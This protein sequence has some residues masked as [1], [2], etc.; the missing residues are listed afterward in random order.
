MAVV[1]LCG[2]PTLQTQFRFKTVGQGTQSTDVLV[3]EEMVINYTY[4][5]LGRQMMILDIGSPVNIAGVSWM[6]QYL[7]KFNLTT[8]VSCQQPFIFGPSKI[9][10]SKTLVELPVLITKLDGRED[11]LIVQRYLVDAEVPFLCGRGHWSLG[12]SI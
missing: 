9:Y 3:A 7:E 12:I 2:S 8:D 6:T 4:S 5:Y 11:V 1:N 10:V